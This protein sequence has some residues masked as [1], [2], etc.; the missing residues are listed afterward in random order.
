MAWNVCDLMKSRSEFVTQALRLKSGEIPGNFTAL[1]QRYGISRK[2]GY[3][4]LK[5]F[6][7]DGLE[8]LKDRPKTPHHQ[9]RRISAKM[10]SSVV[11]LRENHPVWGGRKLHRRLIDLNH[12]E[13][14]APST[15]TRILHRNGKISSQASRATQSYQRFERNAPND[16][17]QMDFKGHFAL[18]EEGKRCHPLTITDDHSRFNI[19]LQACSNE[20]AQTVKGHLIE[21]FQIYGLPV[22]ILCDNGPAWS[23]SQHRNAVG[24]LEAWLIRVGVEVIHGRPYHPQT[25]AKRNAFIEP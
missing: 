19:C 16:L 1:C 2:T 9:P 15:I 11:Q 6:E 23:C 12:K 24:K 8:G 14:P 10:E 3:K 21:S 18:K 20:N 4:W 7:K 25:R 17:W 22:Q 13:V 5:R